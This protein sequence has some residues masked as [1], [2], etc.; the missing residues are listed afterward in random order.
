M[1]KTMCVVL[2]ALETYTAVAMTAH[3]SLAAMKSGTIGEWMAL[4]TI[5]L[6]GVIVAAGLAAAA[7]TIHGYRA[8]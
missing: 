8:D 6:L 3:V 4:P 2:I 7:W 1:I 5:A